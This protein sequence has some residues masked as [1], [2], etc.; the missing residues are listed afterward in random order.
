MLFRLESIEL[1]YNIMLTAHKEAKRKLQEAEAHLANLFSSD[2]VHSIPKKQTPR[3]IET[4]PEEEK[5]AARK[6]SRLVVSPLN[7][8]EKEKKKS[9]KPDKRKPSS[10]SEKLADSSQKIEVFTNP[11]SIAVDNY[12]PI[13]YTA[14]SVLTNLNADIDLMS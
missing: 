5:K 13:I 12:A 7:I 11:W 2:R 4:I 3:S 6:D 1:K 14:K 9:E 10:E 8:D